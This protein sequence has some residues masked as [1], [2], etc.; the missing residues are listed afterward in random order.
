MR[1]TLFDA[2]HEDFRESVRGFLLKEAVPHREAWEANGIIDR[3]FWLKAAAQGFVAFS[4]PEELGGAGLDDF[5]FNVVIDEEVVGT[6]AVGDGFS[7]TNDIVAPYLVELTTPEQQE[8]WLPGLTSGELVAAIAMSEPAAGSDL[9]GIETTASWRGDHWSVSGSKTFV[10][11]G[12][13]AD[14]VIVAAKTGDG[15]GL[16]CVPSDA[17]GFSRGRKLEK[18]GR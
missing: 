12:I 10:T 7:L 15:M 14:L 1:R 11:S 5:R 2:E 13:Q 4:A 9:R 6:G 3:E 16:F 18:I 8:R 17:D